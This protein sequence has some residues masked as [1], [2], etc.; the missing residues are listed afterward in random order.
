V[1]AGKFVFWVNMLLVV[2]LIVIYFFYG[3]LKAPLTVFQSFANAVSWPGEEEV[4]VKPGPC[5]AL[6]KLAPLQARSRFSQS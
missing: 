4:F 3:F 5:S 6:R 1:L 2:V